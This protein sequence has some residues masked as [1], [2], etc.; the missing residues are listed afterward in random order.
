MARIRS[1]KPEFWDSEDTATLPPLVALTYTGLWN[2]ADDEG[3]GRYAP[4]TLH[5]RLHG[6][7]N[8]V[9]LAAT[10]SALTSLADRGLIAL[11]KDAQGS[12]YYWIPSFKRHQKPKNPTPSRLPAPPEGLGKAGGSRREALTQGSPLVDVDGYGVVDGDGGGSG[13]ASSPPLAAAPQADDGAPAGGEQA[14]N[15]HADAGGNG[16]RTEG[17]PA[18][19]GSDQEPTAR[20]LAEAANQ[21]DPTIP[22]EK[23]EYHVHQALQRGVKPAA[24]IEAIRARGGREKLWHILDALPP[25]RQDAPRKQPYRGPSPDPQPPAGLR[26][27]R[28]AARAAVEAKLAELAPEFL[29]PWYQEADDQAKAAKV[30]PQHLKSFVESAVRVRCAKHFGIE[31]A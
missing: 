6:A 29:A 2:I 15:G 25:P 7:R 22:V 12:E 18:R 1:L 19:T 24:A 20:D 9:T 14:G 23:A 11:Y 26:E 31:G 8:G 16:A 21:Q 3:R 17:Q 27:K 5:S 10:R 13:S 28:E 4:L 30:Q